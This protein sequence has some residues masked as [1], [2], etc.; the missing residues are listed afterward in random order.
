VDPTGTYELENET[1]NLMEDPIGYSG[2]I[3]V[4][5]QKSN[6]IVMTFM[7]NKGAPSYNSGSF[8]DTLAYQFNRAIY[9][10]PELDPSCK[11]TFSFT[12]RG[13]TV[14]Q[15]TENYNCGCGFGH[16]VV[17]D[18]YFRRISSDEP[19]LK[20]PLTGQKFDN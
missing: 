10:N 13:V 8:T 6:Q 15:E 1:R 11:I 4:R 9:V 14:K 17:A 5:T 19:E 12:N 16:A 3:Q 7:V 20:D 2:I 18:G